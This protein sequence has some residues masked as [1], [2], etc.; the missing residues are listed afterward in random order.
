MG[1]QFPVGLSWLPQVQCKSFSSTIQ[2][3]RALNLAAATNE[4]TC[5][6]LY[7]IKTTWVKGIFYWTYCIFYS[8]NNMTEVLRWNKKL[9]LFRMRMG[10]EDMWVH[11]NEFSLSEGE[12]GTCSLPGQRNGW[13]HLSLSL[14]EI[15]LTEGT[16]EKSEGERKKGE[17]EVAGSDAYWQKC[18]L[19]KHTAS[20]SLESLKSI[21]ERR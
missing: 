3:V 19:V 10:I 17:R 21:T 6:P 11:R 20:V 16:E 2:P 18:S 1:F 8:S 14:R 12:R 5:F 4:C 15:W 9:P 13:T 7:N